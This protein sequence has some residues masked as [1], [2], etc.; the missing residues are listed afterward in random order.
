MQIPFMSMNLRTYFML[1]HGSFPADDGR[2][3]FLAAPYVTSG[4]DLSMKDRI[5]ETLLQWAM[6]YS[7]QSVTLGKQ[8]S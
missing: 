3:L 1:L 5:V 2:D 7:Q 6:S 8:R 4:T